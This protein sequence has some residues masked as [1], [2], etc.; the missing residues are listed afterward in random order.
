MIRTETVTE[1]RVLEWG[2][3][4]RVAHDDYHYGRVTNL[5]MSVTVTIENVTIESVTKQIVSIVAV[6]TL[7][8]TGPNHVLSEK[9]IDFPTNATML[10]ET[11]WPRVIPTSH[12]RRWN[13]KISQQRATGCLGAT[14]RSRRTHDRW[15]QSAEFVEWRFLCGHDVCIDLSDGGSNFGRDLG[16]N[17]DDSG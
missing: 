11:L 15:L 17:V 3:A 5:L 16:R 2:A 9:P 4:Q 12:V 7:S 10:P 14:R 13:G 6:T 8:M 1:T